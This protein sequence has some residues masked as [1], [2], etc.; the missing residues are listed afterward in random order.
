MT[1]HK[2]EDYIGKEINGKKILSCCK[3]SKGG[4]I[5]TVECLNCGKVQD[6]DFYT[7]IRKSKHPH[8]WCKYCNPGSSANSV[9]ADYIGKVYGYFEIIGDGGKDEKNYTK[10]ICRCQHC[11]EEYNVLLTKLRNGYFTSCKKCRGKC[12]YIGRTYGKWTVIGFEYKRDRNK[13]LLVRCRCECGFEE[14]IPLCHLIK[15]YRLGCVNCRRHKK[16]N[17]CNTRLYNIWRAMKHRCYYTKDQNYQYYGGRGIKVCEEWKNN[18][19]AFYDWS[20]KNGY[21]E[22]LSID[23]IDVDGDYEPNNCRWATTL[24]QNLNRNA[25]IRN[26]SGYVGIS[27]T[28]EYKCGIRWSSE[29]G[30]D[31]KVIK[32]GQYA[33]KKEALDVRNQYIKDHDLDKIGYKIQEYKGE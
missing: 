29:I 23:R 17:K 7:L 28:K 30:V 22:G 11:G 19:E 26:T 4:K 10:V 25:S 33:T 9:V 12:E 21:Q 6:I 18:F 2:I 1:K 5:A 14:D 13:N 15:G 24:Q 3:D 32:L 31:G 20:I 16:H 8:K 27:K